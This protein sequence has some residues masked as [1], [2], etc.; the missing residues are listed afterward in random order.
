M[1]GE[2]L[3]AHQ[4]RWCTD[5]VMGSLF[6]SHLPFGDCSRGVW[7]K[8]QNSTSHLIVKKIIPK[9]SPKII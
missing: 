6:L 9:I 3:V 7:E 5:K 8:F 1:A 2:L 4:H